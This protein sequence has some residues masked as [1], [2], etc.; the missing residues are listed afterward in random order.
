[1]T[2]Q[3]AEQNIEELLHLLQLDSFEYFL[4]EYNSVNGLICDKTHAGWP[5][6]IAAVGMALTVY[7]VGVERG[8][9]SRD[10]ALAR[11]LLTLRFFAGSDQSGG[12]G[13]TGYKGFY[14]HFLDMESGTRAWGSELSSIDTALLIAGMLTAAAYFQNDTPDE[15]EVRRLAGQLYRRVDWTWMLN[16]NTL[17]CHGWTPEHGFLPWRWEGYDEALILYVL[18]LGSPTF[19]VGPDSYTAWTASY[20]WKQVYG[21]EFLYAGPLFIH[22]MSHVWIDFR[23]IQDDFMRRHGSDYFDNSRRATRVQQQ[24]A[25]HNPLGFQQYGEFCWGITASDG[26]G[27]TSKKINGVERIFHDYVA[28]GVPYGPD[29]GTLAPW[30]V[31]A[32]LPFAP[33][34]VLPTVR[35]FQKLQLREVNP[36]GFKASFNP[37]Y[38]CDAQRR[39][40]WVSPY[41]FGIN[42][43]PT[44]IMI[45]NYRSD[46]VWSLTRQ[47]PFIKTGLRRAGFRG[48]WLA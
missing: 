38:P 4:H 3:N 11:T 21:I 24:Y 29:D 7:P 6:S 30:A 47:C 40:G 33:E 14:F 9:M 13:A 2:N 36:Y 28:R 46:L 12:A 16:G 25:M 23:A 35:Y 37:T 1:M 34:I 15:S 19:P 39:C 17:I 26:P 43:G 31:V 41:H 20:E 5:A 42:E 18:A 45:E 10:A 8:F 27:D 48:G 44:V 32:C 22:Q